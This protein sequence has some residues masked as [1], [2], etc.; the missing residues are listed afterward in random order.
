[1]IRRKLAS[2]RWNEIAIGQTEVANIKLTGI[3]APGQEI[4]VTHIG[5]NRTFQSI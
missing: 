2:K 3:I 5:L 4:E 1:M